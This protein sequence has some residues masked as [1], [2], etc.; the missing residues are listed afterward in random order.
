MNAADCVIIGGGQAGLAAS[1]ACTVRGIKHVVLD[2]NAEV[3]HAW[4][5]R[6]DSLRLFTPRS[7]NALAGMPML[8]DPAGL[9]GKDE[10]A[11]YF[12]S[13][14]REFKLPVLLSQRVVSVT[15]RAGI[16]EILTSGGANWKSK[17]VIVATGAH[18]SPFIPAVA[19]GL[20]ISVTQMHSSTY[21]SSTDITGQRVLVVGGG[22]SGA[23]IAV[24]LA[25]SGFNVGI[26]THRPLKFISKQ[27]LGKSFLWWLHVAEPLILSAPTRSRRGRWVRRY[28]D[29][30]IG[31]ELQHLLRTHKVRL[32]TGVSGAR[33]KAIRFTGGS[34][35]DFD[36]VIWCTGYITNLDLLRSLPGALS[37]DGMPIHTEGRSVV[38]GLYYAGLN[39]QRSVASALIMGA[40]RDAQYVVEMLQH[41]LH[42]GKA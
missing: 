24:E 26:S 41:Y 22:N 21:H 18:Q 1:Y 37:T 8:G 29:P 7:L 28:G 38:P 36:S 17:S 39:W 34:S 16:F 6:Y 2:S 27:I 35:G 33:D 40:S 32:Y 9:P 42:L 20:G 5:T 3:G 10:I 31:R 14:A 30:V 19:A 23:Q 11:A 13:Y 4:R 15:Q 12:T 25:Q